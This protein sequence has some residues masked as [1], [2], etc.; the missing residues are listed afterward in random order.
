M[1]AVN[2]ILAHFIDDILPIN[3]KPERFTVTCT[4]SVLC[5]TGTIT[6]NLI[7]ESETQHQFKVDE[8]FEIL[9]TVAY[10]FLK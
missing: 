3:L 7:D 8:I 2:M 6:D 4:K 9:V 5:S 1:L 10:D